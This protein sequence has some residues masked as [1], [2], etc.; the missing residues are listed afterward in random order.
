MY[1]SCLYV[2]EHLH[3][4]FNALQH[5]VEVLPV[6]RHFITRL[7][8]LEQFL[9]DKQLR[10]FY[11]ATCLQGHARVAMFKQYSTVHIDWRWEVL[12]KALDQ[13]IPLFN[14]MKGTVNSQDITMSDG[15][16]CDAVLLTS[17]RA[18]LDSPFFFGNSRRW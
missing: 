3:I 9:A 14:A 17:V 15:G 11:V 10:R 2:P 6:H 5:A 12:N 8:A 16:A 13:L 4:V 18:T 1:P 7:K